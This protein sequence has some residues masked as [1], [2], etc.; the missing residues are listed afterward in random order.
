LE[1]IFTFNGQPGHEI[2]LV[3]DGRFVEERLI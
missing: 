3:Y 2:V 1:N